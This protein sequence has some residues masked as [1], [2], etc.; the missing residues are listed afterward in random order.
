MSGEGIKIYFPEK[1]VN[2]LKKQENKSKV[3]QE[4]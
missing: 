4:A 1:F 2:F 3:I